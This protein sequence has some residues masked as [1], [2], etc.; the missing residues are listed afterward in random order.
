MK[1]E[2][3]LQILLS[4]QLWTK[5]HSQQGCCVWY[6]LVFHSNQSCDSKFFEPKTP[7]VNFSISAILISTFINILMDNTIF[8]TVL[9]SCKAFEANRGWNEFVDQTAITT[10]FL[11][12]L[13]L[14]KL[15]IWIF[16]VTSHRSFRNILWT[17]TD[18]QA[19][20]TTVAFT[21]SLFWLSLFS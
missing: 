8:L 15:H 20:T 4:P 16:L 17:L 2:P 9:T 14:Q 19:R 6:L 5:V 18:C 13:L 21:T 10:Y 3:F 7:T 1:D 11:L 12:S